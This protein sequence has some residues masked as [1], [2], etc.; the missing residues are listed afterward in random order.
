MVTRLTFIFGVSRFET[1]P[2]YPIYFM[3]VLLGLKMNVIAL[4]ENTAAS[5]A[6]LSIALCM[7]ILW[8]VWQFFLDE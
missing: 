7:I 3:K 4:K 5:S 6:D 2:R 1:W 8:E